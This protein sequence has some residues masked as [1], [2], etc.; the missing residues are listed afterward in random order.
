MAILRLLASN[1]AQTTLA[2][3]ISNTATSLTVASGT[4]ALFPQ[5]VS[6]TSLFKLTLIDAATNSLN[7]IVHVTAVSG[8]VFTIVRAQEGTTA[9]SWTVN[10]IAANMVT[11]GTLTQFFLQANSPAMEGTPTAPTAAAGTRTTQVATTE[12]VQIGLDGKANK[13]GDVNTDF[14]VRNNG[15]TGA[16]V[17]NARL[18]FRLSSYAYKGGDASQAFAVA[19]DSGTK[20]AVNNERLSPLLDAKANLNGNDQVNFYVR[21][22]GDSTAAVNNTRLNFVLTNYAAVAGNQFTSFNVGGATSATHAVRL[23]QFQSGNNSNG[24]WVKNP[25]GSQ[26][27]RHNLTIPAN[28]NLIWTFPTGFI[29]APAVFITAINGSFNCWLT[30]IGPNNAGIFN[31][32]SQNLNVN[33]LAIY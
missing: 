20:A 6:G 5:P 19:T 1:N 17:N 16:A 14:Y 23:D 25:G 13:N 7:E 11:A 32:S 15:D 8:D 3:S 24:A 21:N 12:F 27:C 18:E 26:W 30:G 31:A 10:D 2:S 9:R 22:N 33:L 29:S 28:S 4:G